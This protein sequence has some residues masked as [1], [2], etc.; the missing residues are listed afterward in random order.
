M[1][2][3]SQWREIFFLFL[4]YSKKEIE[5]YPRRGRDVLWKGGVEVIFVSF[6]NDR[7]HIRWKNNYRYLRTK[8][9][10]WFVQRE[11][12]KSKA[13]ILYL[14]KTNGYRNAVYANRSVG[15]PTDDYSF[16]QAFDIS[17]RQILFPITVNDGVSFLYAF[18]TVA[19]LPYWF[20]SLQRPLDFKKR[21]RKN[22]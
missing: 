17:N 11:W 20:T 15:V 18:I 21:A 19:V 12:K 1:I 16:Q 3:D 10:L 6:R 9:I 7:S 2:P 14:F 5:M 8:L 22:K 13:E 4:D